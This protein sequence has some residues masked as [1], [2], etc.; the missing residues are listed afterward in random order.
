MIRGSFLQVIETAHEAVVVILRVAI[1]LLLQL[2]GGHNRG[3]EAQD[4]Q[5]LGM[6]LEKEK[7]GGIMYVRWDYRK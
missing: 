6:H 5:S 1:L 3:R 4:S 7:S 2:G